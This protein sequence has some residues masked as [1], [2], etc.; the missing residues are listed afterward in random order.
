MERQVK[1]SV[2]G[3][4][5]EESQVKVVDLVELGE[6]WLMPLL[7]NI[8]VVEVANSVLGW[9]KSETPDWDQMQQTDQP[10]W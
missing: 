1:K 10:D 2:V 7:Q 5:G 3:P 4:V 6:L 8:G 9:N